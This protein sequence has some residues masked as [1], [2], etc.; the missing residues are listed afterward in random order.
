MAYRS[1]TFP[2]TVNDVTRAEIDLLDANNGAPTSGNWCA[3]PRI[4][5]GVIDLSSAA[6]GTYQI[7]SLSALP[8]NIIVTGCWYTVN[9]TFTSGGGD[10]ATLKIQANG[11]DIVAATAI[12]GGGNIWDAGA[13][14]VSL[15][16]PVLAST[17]GPATVTIA[18]QAITSASTLTVWFEYF[19]TGAV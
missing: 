7:G 4:A 8:N 19:Q 11:T 1:R 9:T 10:A 2:A 12:S 5:Y 13:H 6:I 15:S 16:N 17:S 14:G 3:L 18:S